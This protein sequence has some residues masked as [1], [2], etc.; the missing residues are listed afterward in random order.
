MPSPTNL[1]RYPCK[2]SCRSMSLGQVRRRTTQIAGRLLLLAVRTAAQNY[3]VVTHGC[4]SFIITRG[5]DEHETTG[6]AAVA[7]AGFH[8]RSRATATAKEMRVSMRPAGGSVRRWV[9]KLQSCHGEKSPT[10]TK[11]R[12]CTHIICSISRRRHTSCLSHQ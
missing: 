8:L 4:C 5:C 2:A 12:A 9:Y 10:A 6:T 7:H 11:E 3:R 1:R